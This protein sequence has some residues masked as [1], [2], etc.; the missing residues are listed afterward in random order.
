[1]SSDHI[2][3]KIYLRISKVLHLI[4]LSKWVYPIKGQVMILTCL[5]SGYIRHSGM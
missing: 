3:L 4:K 5:G 2:M 1:M